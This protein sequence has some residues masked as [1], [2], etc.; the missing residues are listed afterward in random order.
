MLK[1][2]P[3]ILLF[4]ILAVFLVA[5]SAIATPVYNGSTYADYGINGTPGIPTDSG[6]YIWTNDLERY[7]WSIRWTGNNNGNK[8]WY[9]WFG[10]IEIGTGLDLESYETF[11]FESYHAA[12]NL[13]GDSLIVYNAPFDIMTWEAYA[14]PAFDGINFTI[15]GNLGNV[16]GFNLGSTMVNAD[17]GLEELATG[18]FIGQDSNIPYVLYSDYNVNNETTSQNFEIPAP[19]PEPATMLLLGSGLIGLAAFGRM[20]FFKK[21]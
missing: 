14:G 16:I 4:L 11:Q 10:S 13:P 9:N 1:K 2:L 5:G 3:K 12:P 18:I 21:R 17:A 6:Y 8:Q 7:S 19:V 20:K 15:D